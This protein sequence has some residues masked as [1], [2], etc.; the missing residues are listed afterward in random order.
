MNTAERTKNSELFEKSY[1]K[2]NPEQ[3]RAVD[4]IDGPVLVIAGPGSGK[5]QIL[6]LRVANILKQTD[7]RPAN[8]LCLTFT[9]SAAANMRERLASMI[10]HQAYRVSIN[11]F[12]SFCTDVIGKFPE[13]FYDGASFMPADDLTRLEVLEEIFKDLPHDNPLRKEHP[14]QG[15]IFLEPSMH[16]ISQLKKAGLTPKEF[17]AIVE[18]N[19]NAITSIRKCIERV[20]ESR[21][22]MKILPEV[23]SCA[24]SIR[25]HKAN[26]FPVEHMR[27]L[28]EVVA[29]SL[30]RA[31][32]ESEQNESTGPL[33]AWK[34]QWIKKNDEGTL[35]FKDGLYGEK[36]R[37]L[38]GIYNVYTE[39]MHER[40]YFD[41]DDMLLDVIQAVEKHKTLRSELQEQYHFVLVDEF[42]DTNDAQLRLL[43]LIANAEVNE[44]KPNIM[45]VGDDDQAIYKF[46]GAEVSNM[47]NFQKLFG[48]PAIIVLKNNYRS[49]QDILNVARHMI[50]Q[51]NERLEKLLP[52]LTKE[53]VASGAMEE[54]TIESRNFPSSIHQYAWLA[55]NIKARI[56]A[57]TLASDIAVI[58]RA[59]K[60]L[61]ELV[62]FLHEAGIPVSYERQQNVFEEPHITQLILMARFIASIASKQQPEADEFLPEI[63]S[64][65]FWQISRKTIW[66]ISVEAYKNRK[67]WLEIMLDHPD[68][69]VKAVAVF[70]LE[71]SG[72]AT[73]EP[74]EKMLDYM[75]GSHIELQAADDDGDEPV[76]PAFDAYISPFKTFYFSKEK[77][78]NN[79][80]EYL[81]FLSSLRAFVEA[82]REYKK[83]KRLNIHDLVA[84]V[85]LHTK[86]GILVTDQSPFASSVDAV[87]LLSAHKAKGLEFDTVFVV[88][89]Q[90]EI[91][92]SRGRSSILPFPMNLPI[93]PAGD[94]DDDHLRLFY[95]ALTRAKRHL[96]MTS[97]EINDKG[98]NSSRFG[99]LATPGNESLTEF[100]T[101]KQHDDAELPEAHHLLTSAWEAYN[102][103][104]FVYDEEI[105][106]KKLVEEYQ[107]S[108]THLNNFLDVTRG[109]PRVFLEQ[110]LLLFPH[111]K[112][113]SGAYGTAM[114]GTLERMYG[115]VRA[116]G[117][118]PTL[119]KVIQWFDEGLSA[120]RLGDS[121]FKLYRKQGEAALT[122]YFEAK[123]NELDPGCLI[124]VNF[125][126]QGVK[127]GDAHLA[128]K[129]DKMT[130]NSDGTYTVTDFKTGRAFDGWEGKSPNDKVK[131]YRYR[132]QLLFYKILVENSRDFEHSTVSKGVLEFLE[133][134]KGKIIDLELL[135]EDGEVA[136]LKNLI[137]AVYTK[138]RNL[139]FPDTTKYL[140]D[141]AGI[142]AF[143]EDLL[144]T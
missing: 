37:A 66:E 3:K 106:L 63:M 75:I 23:R 25:N 26:K 107:M 111:A 109:G 53:L 133:P 116:E 130:K 6:S 27:P 70:L 42:Q 47:L 92:A 10:G 58:S 29:D 79:R 110:N 144:N 15:F 57:G 13:H 22:S 127:I 87:H 11:T 115:Y 85:D 81:M 124:E 72:K 93:A 118:K 21:V 36:M 119:A 80:V 128:G 108:V 60:V 88:S 7:S 41:F 113:P 68:L 121:D 24:E 126:N 83:G 18:H 48:D 54:G 142:E 1:R 49:T 103:P 28:H 131:M 5:T 33:T 102:R 90:E 112:I 84:F 134:S 4:T 82:L 71:L 120:E 16:A 125:K 56:D 8:I 96:V 77:F 45:A 52:E 31:I 50:V 122:V 32:T 19:D 135:I 73:H 139:D 55:K 65:P 59:H 17:L 30:N 100:L 123:K 132:R 67:L 76:V 138:I 51:G 99:F 101:P 78:A 44:D 38:A 14:E 89:C 97:Y 86:H 91:W 98:K 35:A 104:P 40:G 140:Q 12:H 46:Q 43:R 141:C 62:P 129:I 136:R 9:D 64:F 95:V 143:E 117:K 39:K 20:F 69:N 105:L 74:L 114:H 94:T 137:E 34:Q 2:L 61:V